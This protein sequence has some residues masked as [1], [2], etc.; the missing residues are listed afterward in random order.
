[1]LGAL[2]FVGRTLVDALLAKGDEVVVLATGNQTAPQLEHAKYL[3]NRM[4]EERTKLHYIQATNHSPSTSMHDTFVQHRPHC[5][6]SL[7][8]FD[9]TEGS[10][11]TTDEWSS[12]NLHFMSLLELS[13]SFG[14]RSVV[15]AW[16][17]SDEIASENSKHN[18]SPA[19]R[20]ELLGSEYHQ[21]HGLNV[22]AVRL[23]LVYGPLAPLDRIPLVLIDQLSR[24]LTRAEE[25][26]QAGGFFDLMFVSD[27]VR[28]IMAALDKHTGY[29]AYSIFSGNVVGW[30][31][32]VAAVEAATGKEARTQPLPNNITNPLAIK[33]TNAKRI[34]GFEAEIS[35]KEGL[36]RTV[37]WYHS[38]YPSSPSTEAPPTVTP[39]KESKEMS[40]S[41]TSVES[42]ST[43]TPSTETPLEEPISTTSV[44]RR[45]TPPEMSNSTTSVENQSTETPNSTTS[46]EHFEMSN[47]TTSVESPSTETPSTETPLEEPISTT[48]VER[49]ESPPT[50]WKEMSNSITSAETA[51][52]KTPLK[53]LNSTSSAETDETPWTE[54]PLEEI[55]NLSTSVEISSKEN[56]AQ[57]TSNSSTVETRTEAP[58]TET[59]LEEPNSTT[60]VD[61]VATP[62]TETPWME[63]SNSTT[64]V[65]TPLKESRAQVMSNS[66]TPVQRK[67]ICFITSVFGESIEEMDKVPSALEAPSSISQ[68]PDQFTFLLFTNRDELQAPGW[69]KVV[70]DLDLPNNIIKSRFPK[71]M[72]WRLKFV[73]DE[74]RFVFY[75]DGGWLPN[76]I[77]GVWK[78]LAKEATSNKGGLIQFI[79]SSSK[80][81]AE[82]LSNIVALKKD[83]AAKVEKERTWLFEQPDFVAN[84]TVYCNMAFG[85][86]PHNKK[87]QELSTFFWNRYSLYKSSWR[88][89]PFWSYTLL[90]Y[91]VTPEHLGYWPQALVNRRLWKRKKGS[92]G[93]N[94]HK[95][96]E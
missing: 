10:I 28:G 2:N 92:V 20:F 85:Y 53:E 30:L 63:M 33:T 40:N 21:K 32:L 70:L 65:E 26:Q 73:L 67:K 4:K 95:Y 96:V 39:R 51:S 44:E 72:S 34:L 41:T 61:L 76:R 57:A 45:E 71:F 89:Q 50:P 66:T 19:K 69:Q 64:S 17:T 31:T 22:A 49:G 9:H 13:H 60:S 15:F 46:V 18:D 54:N 16:S 82:E 47:S 84:A 25:T 35:L 91:N 94:D 24:N 43:E 55:G 1:M 77:A 62:S 27:A 12:S 59:A 88:D 7:E 23:P 3:R 68:N 5:V 48:S 6:C 52:T 11:E 38:A 87:Y 93:F 79:N 81:V 14:V 37:Q 42:P 78:R 36:Q 29:D 75:A 86:D 74:C 58:S 90:H 83:T 80:G 56:P 8:L